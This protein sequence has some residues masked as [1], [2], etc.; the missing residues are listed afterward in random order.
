M[1]DEWNES[2]YNQYQ[3]LSWIG[4]YIAL[5]LLPPRLLESAFLKYK[6]LKDT[7]CGTLPSCQDFQADTH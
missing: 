6:A 2:Q 3:G 7:T 1:W 4:T 5:L